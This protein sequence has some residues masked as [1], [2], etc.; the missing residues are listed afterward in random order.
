MLWCCDIGFLC[1][2][3]YVGLCLCDMNSVNF[4]WVGNEG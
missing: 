1:K 2:V 4:D 3:G